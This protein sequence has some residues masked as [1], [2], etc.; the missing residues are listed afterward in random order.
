MESVSFFCFLFFLIQV[1]GPKPNLNYFLALLWNL[2]YFNRSFIYPFRQKDYS[3]KMP[4]AIMFSAVFFNGVNGSINGC[5]LGKFNTCTIQDLLPYFIIG[6]H[7]F[8]LG[9]YINFKS[10]RILLSLRKPGEQD[11]KIPKGFLFD[12]VTCPNHLGEIIEWLGFALMGM[13]IAALSFAVWTFANLAPRSKGHHKWYK[14]HFKDYPKSR[15]GLI[16]YIR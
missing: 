10:D 9:M 16:P 3:K 15:K 8:A 12:K 1:D 13:N 7:L 6:P 4:L 5:F 11:Y 2:H 14:T